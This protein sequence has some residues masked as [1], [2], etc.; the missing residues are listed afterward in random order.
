MRSLASAEIRVMT[1]SPKDAVEH[2]V[3]WTR[4]HVRYVTSRYT[5]T[6]TNGSLVYLLPLISGWYTILSNF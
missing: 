2:C 4:K 5:R 6:Q 3:H 1:P